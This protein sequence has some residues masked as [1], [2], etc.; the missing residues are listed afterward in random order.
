VFPLGHA[1]FGYLLYIPF[2]W[3]TDYRL[4]YGLTLGALLVGTQFPDVV[5]KPLAYYGVLPS[6]RSFAH[7]L[8]FAAGLLVLLWA[9]TRRLGGR[10]L[11]AAFGF[12]HLSHVLGDIV[13][14]VVT[15]SV[16][17]LT[18]LLWPVFPA[19]QYTSDLVPPWVRVAQ[20]Y[21]SPRLTPG[22]MLLPLVFVAFLVV[23]IGR[24]RIHVR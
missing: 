10:D 18:F 19:P 15:G 4:P 13:A 12:G 3:I 8:F 21:S 16:G 5:D 2:A 6:G 9:A 7:T 20:F 14:T 23:E 1:A 17:D 11:A 24:R 22:V